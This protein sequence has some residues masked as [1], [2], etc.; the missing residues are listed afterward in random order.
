MRRTCA[1]RREAQ[2]GGPDLRVRMLA[3]DVVGQAVSHGVSRP[4]RSLMTM[5]G[6]VL[7]V[8]MLVATLGVTSSA[9]ARINQH[10]DALLATE[11]DVQGTTGEGSQAAF[12]RQA[13]ERAARVQGVL[14]AGVI[15]QLPSS[16]AVSRSADAAADANATGSGSSP[17]VYAASL[18]AL[19]VIGP[20]L[21]A[22]RLFDTV[23]EQHAARVALVGEAAARGLG[24]DAQDLPATV[25][26]DGS[27]FLIVGVVSHVKRHAE[28]L[29]SMIIPE[30]TEQATFGA[31][32]SAPA[33][34]IVATKL[35]Y[36][37][38]VGAVLPATVAPQ[39]PASVAVTTPPDAGQLQQQ[40][41]S[42]VSGL[43]VVLALIG[44]AV[45]TIGIA[46]TTLVSVLE[47]VG[48]IGLRRAI[49]ARRAQVA[50][51]FLLESLLLGAIGG[52]LGGS[53][54]VCGVTCVAIAKGWSPVVP[55]WICLSAPALGSLTGILAGAYPA[56]RAARV[57]PVLALAR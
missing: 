2:E 29:L 22:G 35:G 15:R 8:G 3:R 9:R 26:I 37:N 14:A 13:V 4:W 43:F 38:A 23:E 45:G 30:M 18:G 31:S 34:M 19:S 17:T 52:V 28:Y 10:F 55:L 40:V 56:A 57:D 20:T 47:R 46:N 53:L 12:D 39:A 5:L 11:V 24:I 41:S 6:T 54:G 32:V 33:E 44:L 42:D 36:A 48:E 25:Y 51:Q 50:L 49:G 1:A 21:S 16:I 7:G 27:D